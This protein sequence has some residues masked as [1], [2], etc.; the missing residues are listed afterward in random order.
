MGLTLREALTLAEPLRRAKVLAGERGLDRVVEAVNVMEVPDILEW[1]RPG[2]LLVT[3]LYPLRDNAAAMETLVP[4]LAEKGLVGLAITPESYVDQIPECMI[5]AADKLDFPL[6]ELPPKVSF[7]DIIQPLT[8]HI[9]NIQANEL[10]QSEALLRQF[11]DLILSGGGYPEIA[12]LM[13]KTLERPVLIVDR[14]RRLLGQS[15]DAAECLELFDRGYGEDLY[16]AERV[17]PEEVGLD[18]GQARLWRDPV[19]GQE[20]V[21]YPIRASSMVLGD[22]V[23]C[24]A[25]PTPIPHVCKVALEHGATVTAL[26]MMELQALSQV[27]QQFQNEIL[28]G[29]LSERPEVLERTVKLAQHMG[30]RLET[31]YCLVVVAPDLPV[32]EML[33]LQERRN[34]SAV[35]TSLYLARRYI[36]VLNPRAVFWRQGTRLIVFFSLAGLRAGTK[37]LTRALHEVCQRVAKENPPHT[38]SIGISQILSALHGF[39]SAYR[40]AM[41]SLELGRMLYPG[42][43]GLVI[44]NEE[45]GLLRLFSSAESLKHLGE[46]CERTLAPLLAIDRDGTLLETLR[47][48]L[49]CGQNLRRTA[50]TLGVHYNTARYRLS[51]VRTA[52]GP[53]LD[54]PADRLTLAVALHFLP[55]VRRT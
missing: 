4:Q 51:R 11:L 41:Q 20:L 38:V 39:P 29:L 18:W 44:H 35:D 46:L 28:E 17:V 55:L 22:I 33:S 30:I 45:L 21:F 37:E 24:G 54:N 34:R 13:A 49:E 7:I 50:E 2:E 1:V 8:S 6:I 42:Q 36:R 16:L 26:K 40:S 52:L 32:G 9:L 47:T 19:K 23:V 10:R 3:T 48:Y 27:D 14:F 12:G 5:E 15:P 53:I 43:T 31:P 25:L